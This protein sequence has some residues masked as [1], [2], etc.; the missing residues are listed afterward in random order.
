M[1]PQTRTSTARELQETEALARVA[2]RHRVQQYLADCRERDR[3]ETIIAY[4]KD[5]EEQWK[6]RFQQESELRRNR[7][8]RCDD[9]KLRCCLIFNPIAFLP[10]LLSLGSIGGKL[11]PALYNVKHADTATKL[12]KPPKRPAHPLDI[13][14]EKLRKTDLDKTQIDNL[15]HLQKC[16]ACKAKHVCV[17]VCIYIS[18]NHSSLSLLHN[19]R[20]PPL[21]P[22]PLLHHLTALF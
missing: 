4:N 1:P 19:A 5:M 8:D 12:T 21:L 13:I 6:L 7:P 15:D 2:E 20:N 10:I 17:C 3:V 14:S 11:A 9:Y 22:P 16:G 18:L